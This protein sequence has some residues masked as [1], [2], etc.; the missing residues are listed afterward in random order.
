MKSQIHMHIIHAH[1]HTH[2]RFHIS[3]TTTLTH[4]LTR[5][6]S[7]SLSVLL[8]YFCVHAYTHL[9]KLCTHTFRK[10]INVCQSSHCGSTNWT[11]SL[12]V[13]PS[14]L[15]CYAPT[16]HSRI[17]WSPPN[18]I[19]VVG[20]CRCLS[21][22]AYTAWYLPCQHERPHFSWGRLR[23]KIQIFSHIFRVFTIDVGWHLLWQGRK[24]ADTLKKNSSYQHF[25]VVSISKYVIFIW[26][27]GGWWKGFEPPSLS[28]PLVRHSHPTLDGQQWVHIVHL[29]LTVRT[30]IANTLLFVYVIPYKLYQFTL[31]EPLT[32][33]DLMKLTYLLYYLECGVIT[34]SKWEII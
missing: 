29:T 8:T 7:L 24:A 6:V 11:R 31:L 32:D 23:R 1:T 9:Y 16:W 12:G 34:Q 18:S 20:C 10:H 3:L 26:Q 4:P 17:S 27:E 2:T 5:S 30:H 15:W 19:Y 21:N 33:G 28:A 25:E 13:S 22:L 14:I